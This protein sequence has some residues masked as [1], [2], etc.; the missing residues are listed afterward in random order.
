MYHK[1]IINAYE[2]KEKV[3]TPTKY[4]VMHRPEQPPKSPMQNRLRVNPS[5]SKNAY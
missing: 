4:N 5:K 2:A 1:G 3:Q